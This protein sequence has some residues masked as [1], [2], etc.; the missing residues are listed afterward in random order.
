[1]KGKCGDRVKFV[2]DQAK[3][4]ILAH[5]ARCPRN[6]G[7]TERLIRWTRPENGWVKL[8]T[9][10]VSRGNPGAAAA[11]GVLRD[12]MGS[13]CRGFSPNIG[14]CMTPLAEL[15]GVY[16]SLL[17]AWESKVQRVEME[18]DLEIVVKFLKIGI[19]DK[20]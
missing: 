6:T 18:I 19:S 3:E 7:R 2:R 14:T 13:W 20:G 11:G 10:G 9:D 8:N 15:W 16:Y 5:G 12:E 1:M 4:I 17:M